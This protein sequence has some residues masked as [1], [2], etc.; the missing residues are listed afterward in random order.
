MWRVSAH[1]NYNEKGLWIH[2]EGY[3]IKKAWLEANGK[4]DD[5]PELR[6][7]EYVG[8]GVIR[9]AQ[10]PG[11]KSKP[12]RSG[13]QRDQDHAAEQPPRW[14]P[15]KQS[16]PDVNGNKPATRRVEFE[17][18]KDRDTRGG[19]PRHLATI[20]CGTC[21][22]DDAD[23]DTTYRMCCITVGTSPSFKAAT[24]FICQ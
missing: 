8:G 5:Y 9:G 14:Q 21:D 4:G 1:P 11:E 7:H 16:A 19:T 17:G 13:R 3:R 2:S 24:F 20:S 23:V 18:V 12:D 10:N 22:C 6:W 15:A